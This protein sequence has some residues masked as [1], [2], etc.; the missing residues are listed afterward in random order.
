MKK[1]FTLAAVLTFASAVCM[2][3]PDPKEMVTRQM[4]SYKSQLTLT[5]EQTPKV[6]AILLAQMEKRGKM[7]EQGQNG[8]RETM[9][10]NMRKMEEENAAK[11]KEVL[12]ADQFA[13][14][15]KMM[16]ER[17]ANRPQMQ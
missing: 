17:R 12:T 16:E 6:E 2:A 14:Y 9:M 10:A 4:E 1:L 13:K 11:F 15:Q 3:Q 5:A 8:D 7:F